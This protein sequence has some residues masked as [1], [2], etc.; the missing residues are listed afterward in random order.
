MR[1]WQLASYQEN[2]TKGS[3]MSH[4]WLCYKRLRLLSCHCSTDFSPCTPMKQAA[5]ERN[6]ILTTTWPWMWIFSPMN[7]QILS[8]PWLKPWLRNFMRNPELEG[9]VKLHLIPEPKKLWDNNGVFKSYVLEK[10]YIIGNYIRHHRR[11]IFI[12]KL[13][14]TLSVENK[15]KSQSPVPLRNQR[16]RFR[17]AAI[18]GWKPWK[19]ENHKEWSHKTFSIH[20]SNSDS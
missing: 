3:G 20:T 8:K 16:T 10:F 2:K 12:M 18:Q 1:T 5:M 9:Q 19:G 17:V 15:S 4:L 13:L 6:W 11:S 14:K 7:F